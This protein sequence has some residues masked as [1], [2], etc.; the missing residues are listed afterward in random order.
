[1]TKAAADIHEFETDS[2]LG[3]EAVGRKVAELL[4]PPRLLIL[5]GD[6]GTG[7]TTLVKGIAAAMDA[8]D[9]DEV[10]SPTFTLVHEYS[11]TLHGKPVKLLHLDLY[12]LEGERQVDSLGLDD[13]LTPDAVVLVEW[14]EKF[15]S[16]RKRA[17]G[18][19]TIVSAGG[20]TRKIVVT[21]N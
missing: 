15:K 13:M 8:A 1:M 9:P 10:T 11:G 2:T 20:D 12:R 5:S 6:L 21:L 4:T 19:I 3:T 16:I 7:K 18:E 14:G 17:N